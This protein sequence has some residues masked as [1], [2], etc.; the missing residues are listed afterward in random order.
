MTTV[1]QMVLFQWMFNTMQDLNLALART[2]FVLWTVQIF[3]VQINQTRIENTIVPSVKEEAETQLII[4]L[5]GDQFII[6][7]MI[8]PNKI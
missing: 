7:L 1:S 2:V 5:K 4:T 8:F 6:K 3:A